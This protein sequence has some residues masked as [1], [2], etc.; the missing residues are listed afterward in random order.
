MVA[1]LEEAYQEEEGHILESELDVGDVEACQEEEL[2]NN[3]YDW[4]KKKN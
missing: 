3:F 1:F 4:E 2:Q